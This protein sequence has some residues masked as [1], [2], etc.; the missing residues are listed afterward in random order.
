MTH[1]D[2]VA[3]EPKMQRGL[4]AMERDFAAIRT[5]RASTALVE[6]IN[7][8]YYG[9]QTPLNQ[10]AGIGTPDTH[11]IVI[12]APPIYTIYLPLVYRAP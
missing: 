4:E 1:P 11:P 10:S 9:T 8:D 3:A 7:V 2:V 12:T 5:G 6:R